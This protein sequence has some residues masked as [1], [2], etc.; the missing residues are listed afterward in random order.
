[1]RQNPNSVLHSTAKVSG[2]WRSVH[3]PKTNYF[4]SKSIWRYSCFIIYLF[5]KFFAQSIASSFIAYYNQF[6]SCRYKR[7]IYICLCVFIYTYILVSVCAVVEVYFSFF[8]YCHFAWI[9]YYNFVLISMFFVIV[10]LFLWTV[11]N[12][13]SAVLSGRVYPFLFTWVPLGQ[14]SWQYRST[15]MSNSSSK[16]PSFSKFWHLRRIV[17]LSLNYI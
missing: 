15:R 8:F 12:F 13:D 3:F 1:M 5:L 9:V 16:R 14:L 17:D 7:C 4:N 11:Q 6:V 2:S 10:F